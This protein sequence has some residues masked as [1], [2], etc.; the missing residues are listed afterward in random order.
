METFLINYASPFIK[1]LLTIIVVLLVFCIPLIIKQFS[2]IN[3]KTWLVLFLI[4]IFSLSIRLFIVPHANYVYHDEFSHVNIAANISVENGFCE[5]RYGS[6]AECKN[7]DLMPWPPAYHS[8]LSLV[9]NVFSPSNNSAFLVN[10]IL[11]SLTAVL[12]FFIAYLIFKDKP[13]SLAAAIIFSLIPVNLKFSGTAAYDIFSIFWVLLAYLVFLI[14]KRTTSI[15]LLWL[16]I[17][18][19]IFTAYIRPE[20]FMYFSFI[21]IFIYFGKPKINTINKILLPFTAIL[22]MVP[23][24]MQIYYGINIMQSPGYKDSLGLKLFYLAQYLPSNLYFFFRPSYNS[25]L[26]SVFALIGIL[27]LFKKNKTKLLFY[28]CFFLLFILI[29]SSFHTGLFHHLD[30]SRYSLILYLPLSILLLY[31]VE[32]ILAKFKGHKNEYLI[33]IILIIFIS[34]LPTYSY[35]NSSSIFKPGYDLL[36]EQSQQLPKDSYIISYNTSIIMS[37]YKSKS[38]SPYDFFYS[39]IDFSGDEVYLYKDIWWEQN[40]SYSTQ[41]EKKLVKIYNFETI[42]N[43]K[44]AQFIKLN[45]K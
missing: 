42:S 35:I 26:F 24:G 29:Y 11:G 8:F 3:K 33:I 15:K 23:L 25:I 4:F 21:L 30:S 13:L 37:L 19:L 45:K 31:G 43:T 7:C 18:S 39:K 1:L 6:I 2:G 14:Y 16:T 36:L 12:F 28:S 34:T 27:V 40:Y 9:F 10:I 22:S 5:C 20:Y 32:F 44:G 38:I 17:F 41:F